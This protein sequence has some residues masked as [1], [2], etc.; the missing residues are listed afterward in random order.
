MV[1][2]VWAVYVDG[3]PVVAMARQEE[4]TAVL[5]RV[6]L[7]EGEGSATAQWVQQVRVDRADGKKLSPVDAGTASKKL[8]EILEVKAE[9]GVIY[10]DAL[11]VVALPS[12]A[13]ARKLLEEI[14]SGYAGRL[15]SV[16]A[17]PTFK[18][19]VEV[20]RE[21]AEQEMWGDTETARALLTGKNTGEEQEHQVARGD[22]AWSISQKY[23]L[24]LASLRKLNPSVTLERLQVG[25]RLL[26]GGKAEPL[27][28]V[29]TEGRLSETLPTSFSTVRQA[30]PQ[31]FVGKE[32][33]KSPGRPGTQKVTYRVRCENGQVVHR[34]VVSRTPLTPAKPRIVVVG[35]RPRTVQARPSTRRKSRTTRYRSRRRR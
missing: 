17:A 20:R 16:D 32:I 13:E 31:M 25:Q 11:P 28:T 35:T 14:Q 9:R 26:V 4:M 15:E 8:G 6:R 33:L 7:E 1:S 22:N 2:R 10:I 29:V 27:I 34:D 23:S 19:A 24:N 21:A 30:S 12:E 3:K 5:E 18:E